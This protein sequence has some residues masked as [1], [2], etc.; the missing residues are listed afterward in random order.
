MLLC[1]QTSRCVFVRIHRSWIWT[2][3]NHRSQRSDRDQ[4]GNYFTCFIYSIE[5]HW[6][7]IANVHIIIIDYVSIIWYNKL[8][9]TFIH[10]VLS[11]SVFLI[12]NPLS[13][14]FFELGSCWRFPFTQVL[15]T[16][17][18]RIYLNEQS[19]CVMLLLC[20]FYEIFWLD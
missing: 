10:T 20:Y 3:I 14:D 4:C 6:E 2:I 13:L 12:D 9:N 8:T 16:I 5:C 19:C 11:A 1:V 17:E 18:T 15:F 7:H